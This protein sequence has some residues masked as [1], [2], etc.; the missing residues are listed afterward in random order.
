MAF[1]ESDKRLLREAFKE[2]LQD[3]GIGGN[4]FSQSGNGG[5]SPRPPGGGSSN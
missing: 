4:R 1:D 3:S 5:G 2:A